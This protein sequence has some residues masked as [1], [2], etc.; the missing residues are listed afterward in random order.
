MPYTELRLDLFP[1]HV[2][3]NPGTDAEQ[4]LREARILVGLD[5]IW[6]YA[7]NSRGAIEQVWNERYEQIDGRRTTGWTAQLGDGST[8]HFIRSAGCGCGNPLR[9]WL[10]P[11]ATVQGQLL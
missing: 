3:L 5:E 1:A 6:V 4:A 7:W 2:T 11:F 8:L 9:G 10:P